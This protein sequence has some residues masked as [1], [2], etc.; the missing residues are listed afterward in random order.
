[1]DKLY[2]A[3]VFTKSESGKGQNVIGI[4]EIVDSTTVKGDRSYKVYSVRK[5]LQTPGKLSAFSNMFGLDIKPV[6]KNVGTKEVIEYA[7][8]KESLFKERDDKQLLVVM[9]NTTVD[10]LNEASWA[11]SI[12]KLEGPLATTM[13]DIK[14][15]VLEW[16][17]TP[18]SVRDYNEEMRLIAEAEAQEKAKKQ[19]ELDLLAEKKREEEARRSEEARKAAEEE[20]RRV[21]EEE[22]RR[23]EEAARKA[24]EERLRQEQLEKERLAREE[25]LAKEAAKKRLEVAKT[26]PKVVKEVPKTN[27]KTK[28]V[29]VDYGLEREY[30]LDDCESVEG[31]LKSE[32]MYA[33]YEMGMQEYFTPTGNFTVAESTNVKEYA[34]ATLKRFEEEEIEK[35]EVIKAE[36]ARKAAEEAAA[37][38]A[39]EE[40]EAKAMEETLAQTKEESVTGYTDSDYS[41]MNFRPYSELVTKEQEPLVYIRPEQWESLFNTS[42]IA[43]LK[44][45]DYFALITSSEY[46]DVPV[47]RGL[48]KLSVKETYAGEDDDIDVTDI[49]DEE[50]QQFAVEYIPA[51]Y[52]LQYKPGLTSILG[53]GVRPRLKIDKPKYNF[54][55]KESLRIDLVVDRCASAL[56]FTKKPNDIT[57]KE[58]REKSEIAKQIDPSL[59]D[60]VILGAVSSEAQIE[61]FDLR[62]FMFN[63]E[64]V[65][66]LSDRDKELAAIYE[67]EQKALYGDLSIEYTGS[68][69]TTNGAF[70]QMNAEDDKLFFFLEHLE[71]LYEEKGINT[72]R[73]EVPNFKLLMPGLVQKCSFTD[74]IHWK[75]I[76]KSKR[77]QYFRQGKSQD[78]I[79][80]LIEQKKQCIIGGY[81]QSLLGILENEKAMQRYMISF[82]K[83]AVI[84]EKGIKTEEELENVLASGYA[85]KTVD[86]YFASLCK[87]AF[88]M[89]RSYNNIVVDVD[90]LNCLGYDVADN[91]NILS[92]N[93][94]TIKAKGGIGKSTWIKEYDQNI[95]VGAF[96]SL[97]RESFSIL[98]QYVNTEISGTF[99]WIDTFFKL[100]RWGD[101]KGLFLK[102]DET[103][104]KDQGV[105]F[106]YDSLKKV[107]AFKKENLDSIKDAKIIPY[108]T[109]RG[110]FNV[111]AANIKARKQ[112]NYA[113]AINPAL[114]GTTEIPR[115]TESKSPDFTLDSFIGLTQSDEDGENIRNT[116]VDL[117]T[118]V[119]NIYKHDGI[120]LPDGSVRKVEYVHYDK[121]LQ[122]IVVDRE[123][124][125]LGVVYG[126]SFKETNDNT[127]SHAKIGNTDNILVQNIRKYLS[128]SV[129]EKKSISGSVSY[130]QSDYL[131]S[132]DILDI[133]DKCKA[134]LNIQDEPSYKF[135]PLEV[136]LR[137]LVTNSTVANR[138]IEKLDDKLVEKFALPFL[139]ESRLF[140]LYKTKYGRMT[141][142]AASDLEVRLN[143]FLYA[144]LLT[145]E[146]HKGIEIDE[147]IES[148]HMTDNLLD[149]KQGVNPF[150]HSLVDDTG[151]PADRQRTN[152]FDIG[153]DDRSKALYNELFSDKSKPMSIFVY[154]NENLEIRLTKRSQSVGGKT[155]EIKYAWFNLIGDVP[156]IEGKEPKVAPLVSLQKTF[157][158]GDIIIGC[159]TYKVQ[160][161]AKRLGLLN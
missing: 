89:N 152:Y 112:L 111:T 27:G 18:L 154:P 86:D 113:I 72:K 146:Y 5:F 55:F 73:L 153:A 87:V 28:Y 79:A 16:A 12:P 81:D 127:L 140:A 119:T 106:D 105:V 148:V 88:V 93:K 9:I 14:L 50:D 41:K 98:K 155:G 90:S 142:G 66:K 84:R 24:E 129:K 114:L 96:E 161:V 83:A 21:A 57:E 8:S 78:E 1:M 121:A 61:L 124:F 56:V 143:C 122:R 95:T 110:L 64:V 159:S 141:E 38:K 30:A 149:W 20:A 82:Y 99:K 85:S 11:S 76:L 36:E 135:N 137:Y 70:M 60:K 62:S 52:I 32:Y 54:D 37:R 136:C 123:L 138:S 116:Y 44:E 71:D 150:K 26:Y 130:V 144:I 25:Q 92:Y 2:Y 68:D 23:A 51:E 126:M 103:L 109:F 47:I 65:S 63:P 53:I 157:K 100:I 91:G 43:Q 33:I 134:E 7:V 101:N 17:S 120:V 48:L 39:E 22:A 125:E 69:N 49:D 77:E 45:N 59:L 115:D 139:I 132:K 42:G 13:S 67:Q 34:E 133:I 107:P 46:D 147:F 58:I 94:Y 151:K 35:R 128:N 118:F 6:K 19:A 104:Q 10:K 131:I 97:K 75:E 40:A 160:E 145:S 15:K 108:T 74:S 158:N 117:V 3:V 102:Y 29:L 31:I 80:E 4:T 156:V